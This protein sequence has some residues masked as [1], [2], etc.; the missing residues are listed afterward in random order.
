MMN[1][2]LKEKESFEN[3]E[4]NANIG[5]RKCMRLRNECESGKMY[6]YLLISYFFFHI[7]HTFM[8]QILTQN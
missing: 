5:L 7:S 1:R 8:F 4:Q 3:L 6:T 2:H